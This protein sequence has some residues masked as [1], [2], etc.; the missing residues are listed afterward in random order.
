METFR[1]LEGIEDSTGMDK[2]VL[3]DY[4]RNH[5]SVRAKMAAVVA[6][7]LGMPFEPEPQQAPQEQAPGGASGLLLANGQPAPPSRPAPG[8]V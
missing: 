5:P 7:E 6:E 1:K 3:K 4:V 8:G 2:G